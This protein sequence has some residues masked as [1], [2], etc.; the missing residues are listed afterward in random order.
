MPDDG[1]RYEII[2]GMLQLIAKVTGDEV[3]SPQRPF[4]VAVC[5]ARRSMAYAHRKR[6]LINRRGAATVPRRR[7]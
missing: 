4:S 5:P 2:D 3:F 7:V 6:A 1:R